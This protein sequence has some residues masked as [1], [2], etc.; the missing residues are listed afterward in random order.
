M[1]KFCIAVI[2]TSSALFP[3][4]IRGH[5]IVARVAENHL[6]ENARTKVKEFLK[7]D[8]L[9]KVANEADSYRSHSKWKCASPFHYVSIEDKE[10]YINA[11]K[12][13]GGD[14]VRALYYFEDILRDKK[15][16]PA[17]RALALK[18]LVHLVGDIHQPLHVGR[19]CDRG[20]NSTEVSWFK[21]KSN[22]H[23]V[24]DV[25]LINYEELS[26]SEY[27]AEIDASTKLSAGKTDEKTLS[28]WSTATYLDWTA[29]A[30]TVRTQIYT[31]LSKDG[32]KMAAAF[33]SC[34]KTS[35]EPVP[36]LEYAYIERNRELLNKQLLKAGIR[37]AALLNRIFA[38]TPFTAK[39][40]KVREELDALKTET[41]N[42]VAE[43]IEKATSR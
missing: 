35:A 41:P 42:P 31:C 14:V 28:T 5:R 33:G 7:E 40:M 3:W 1:L 24:W 32:C 16:K 15:S 8:T 43:C 2:L 6:T 13:A 20:G 22:L 21:A 4:G 27:A 9:T 30:Q 25:E 34:D 17:A 11:Q 23:K 12:A 38:D 19:S 26:F 18:W 10:T 37:L 29:E 36:N 39:E